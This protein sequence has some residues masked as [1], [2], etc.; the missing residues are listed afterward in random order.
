MSTLCGSFT[1]GYDTGFTTGARTHVPVDKCPTSWYEKFNLLQV[2]S[3]GF[4]NVHRAP[5]S[6]SFLMRFRHQ[7]P[8]WCAVCARGGTIKLYTRHV[9]QEVSR[10][11]KPSKIDGEI[12]AVLANHQIYLG[13]CILVAVCVMDI[14]S[15]EGASG[16]KSTTAQAPR[17]VLSPRPALVFH[18][19]Q[20][21]MVKRWE[22]EC[23]LAFSHRLHT[24]DKKK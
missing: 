18:N 5:L 22:R 8:Q 24:K 9:T 20:V 2:R 21:W 19:A 16:V 10:S 4:F 6:A 1:P 13:G 12:H 17:V 14:F 7:A 3:V 11:T 15:D 23:I